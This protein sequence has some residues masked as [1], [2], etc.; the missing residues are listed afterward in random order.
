ML[1]LTTVCYTVVSARATSGQQ[2]TT[3]CR[4]SLFSKSVISDGIQKPRYTRLNV[5]E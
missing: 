1:N 4:D 3:K 5:W 2:N